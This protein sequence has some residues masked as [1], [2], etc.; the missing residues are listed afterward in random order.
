MKEIKIYNF[1]ITKA[2]PKRSLWKIETIS[3][4]EACFKA[5]E[6]RRRRKGKEKVIRINEMMT[7]HM[8]K[9]NQQKKDRKFIGVLFIRFC[10]FSFLVAHEKY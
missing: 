9:H 10:I 1:L 4:C 7:K 8:N 3:E 5:K 6:T 2:T